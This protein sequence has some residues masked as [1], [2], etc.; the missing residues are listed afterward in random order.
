MMKRATASAGRTLTGCA[1]TE[2]KMQLHKQRAERTDV[3]IPQ[4]DDS[5][6]RRT[7]L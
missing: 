2:R 5:E 4:H 1:R 7:Q 6:R 3:F